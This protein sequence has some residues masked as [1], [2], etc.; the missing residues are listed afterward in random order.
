MPRNSKSLR[1][2]SFG[3]IYNDLSDMSDEEVDDHLSEEN[4]DSD[5]NHDLAVNKSQS[6]ADGGH[7][8]V[9]GTKGMQETESNDI[10]IRLSSYD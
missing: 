4:E 9:D 10:L 5:A 1:S 7:L 6:I 3:L 2:K 8:T